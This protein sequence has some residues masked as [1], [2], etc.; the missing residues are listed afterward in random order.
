MRGLYVAAHWSTNLAKVSNILQ[1][2]TESPL[3]FLEG[4]VETFRAYSPIDPEAKENRSAVV[5]AFIKHAMPDTRHKLQKIDGLA[6]K[7]TGSC[8]Q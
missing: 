1:E 3:A 4:I 6:D 8:Q 7:S 5:M 2:K